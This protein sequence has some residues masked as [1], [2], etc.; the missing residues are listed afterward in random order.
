MEVALAKGMVN[1]LYPLRNTE[2]WNAKTE[3]YRFNA[4]NA[5]DL[6][7]QQPPPPATTSSTNVR[8]ASD[9]TPT[10]SHEYSKAWKELAQKPIG[11][12]QLEYHR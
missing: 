11:L 5:M 6:P 3:V 8:E 10:T 1:E 12:L 7:L 4:R 9:G 2:R